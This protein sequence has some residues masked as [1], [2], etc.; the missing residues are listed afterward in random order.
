MRID[1]I[2]VGISDSDMG[3]ILYISV[4]IM[5]RLMATREP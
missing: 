3:L 5:K 4:W 2:A 1:E